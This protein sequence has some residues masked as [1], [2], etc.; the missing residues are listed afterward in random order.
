MDCTLSAIQYVETG[1][2]IFH[3]GFISEV[4]EGKS[5]FGIRSCDH[6][7]MVRAINICKCKL[8]EARFWH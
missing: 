4:P 8:S 2:K 5:I 3:Q 6:A 1:T 7:L